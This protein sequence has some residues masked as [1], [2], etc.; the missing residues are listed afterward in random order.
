MKTI[1]TQ[2]N[3]FLF[4]DIA[5]GL[6]QVDDDYI[7]HT[8]L[9]CKKWLNGEDHFEFNTSGSTGTPTAI[10]ASRKQM[11]ASALA[12]INALG[13]TANA[14]IYL[15]INTKMIGGAMMLVRSMELGCDITI[16]HP[17]SE[18]IAS[19]P[20]NHPY[21]FMSLVPMQLF[22]M[23][24]DVVAQKKLNQ[25]TH[26]L[27]GGAP[28]T[29]QLLSSLSKLK[30][31]VWQTYGMTETLSHVALRKVGVDTFYKAIDGIQL[32]TDER[33]CLCIRGE[34]TNNQWLL[35]NDVVNLVDATHFEL[36]GRMDDV[37]NSGGIKIFTYDVERAIIE[38][39]NDLEM[40]H[41][42][43]FVCKQKDDKYGE[44]VVA[45]M[46]GKPL[47]EGVINEIMNYCVQKLGKYAA[48]K[49]IYFTNQFVK[50]ESGKINK[51]ATL[52]Q[53]INK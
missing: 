39:M 17:S 29:E 12:T 51:Q 6:F 15:C 52:Q 53:L 35:T 8:L 47:D 43:L 3:A 16:V 27:L 20:E 32:K 30:V 4:D 25:F 19:L 36:L 18:P 28:A 48:P 34:V 2:D 1:Y 26:I 13:L 46:F 31:A 44:I 50:L 40:P 9:F 38:K 5:N 23:S 14:H 45:V 49:H 24:D 41:K 22:A 21:T 33:S 7:K 11:Q 42:P 10:Q 37:I